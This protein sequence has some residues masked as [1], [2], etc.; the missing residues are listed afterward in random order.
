MGKP[1]KPH[2]KLFR[3]VF[4]TRE[5]QQD[6]IRLAFPPEITYT[7]RMETVRDVGEIIEEAE[8]SPGKHFA[9]ESGAVDLLLSVQTT[10]GTEELVYILVEH[11]SY[12]DKR[13]AIQLLRY[14]AGH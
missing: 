7:C 13:V 10:F 2:E 8:D 1:A 12:R 11:K 14:V 6:L 5:A 4:S 3:L 9:I